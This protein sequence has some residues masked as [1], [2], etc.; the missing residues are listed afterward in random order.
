MIGAATGGVAVSITGLGVKVP[1]RV[2]TNEDLKQYVETSD[3]WIRERTGIR[4]R[5]MAA[6]EEALSD[7]S[8]PAAR[9]ALAQA[10]IEGEDVDLLI[11]ATVTPDMAFPSTAALLAD[12]LGA[13]EAA[14]YD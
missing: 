3:E 6:K 14:A 7:V 11:V 8:L 2:V 9:Q 13:T 12:T 1:D 10:G 5:R 4:E